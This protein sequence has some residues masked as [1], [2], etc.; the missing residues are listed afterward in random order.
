MMTKKKAMS[1]TAQANAGDPKANGAPG[2]PAGNRSA[3][4]KQLSDYESAL[5]LFAQ[6]RYAEARELFGRAAAGP[7]SNI[8]DKA[9]THIQV[10]ERKTRTLDLEFESAD[11]HF[12]YAVERLNARDVEKAR[13][14]LSRALAM[15][16][17]A[18]HIVYTMALC[19]GLSGD[20]SGACENLK[21]AIELEPKNRILARQDP[22]FAT[23]SL[24]IPG[25]RALLAAE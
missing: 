16:P 20:P 23:L 21:R 17:D 3:N 13:H 8:A 9:R 24:Q 5:K 1:A 7:A 11:D 22:E 18:E 19:C 2:V 6:R 14:H 15:K 25:V 4:D 10:C 12:N